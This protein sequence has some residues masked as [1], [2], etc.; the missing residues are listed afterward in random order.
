MSA[1]IRRMR[2][3]VEARKETARSHSYGREQALGELARLEHE[4]AR[5]ERTLEVWLANQRKTE[6]QIQQVL[7]RI[8]TVQSS[9]GL[10]SAANDRAPR[11]RKQANTEEE[12]VT[13]A[14]EQFVL[15]Y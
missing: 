15:Q 11:N 1:K 9:L 14:D 3:L 2:D 13:P 8:E 10:I 6:H 4:R 12:P 5:L 7:Q